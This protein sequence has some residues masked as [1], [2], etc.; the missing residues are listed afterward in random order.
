MV[1]APQ[2]L[3]TGAQG[4]LGSTLLKSFASHTTVLGLDRTAG[5]GIQAFDLTQDDYSPLHALKPELIVHCAALTDVDRCQT[6]FAQAY[7]INA[8]A[9]WKLAHTAR[10]LKAR[11]VYISTDFVFD[12]V[13]GNYTEEAS[14]NPINHYAMTKYLGELFVEKILPDALILR[15][16]ILYGKSGQAKFTNWAITQL[17]EGRPIKVVTDQIGTPTLVDDIAVALR[18]LLKQQATGLYH[19]AGADA[20]SRYAMAQHIA[21][22][23]HFDPSLVLPVTSREFPQVAPRPLNTS[24]NTRK[25]QEA[26][27]TMSTFAEG[28]R[29]MEA[30]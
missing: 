26:G 3:I 25:I 20:L 2:T 24:L 7:A 27:I 8:A 10:T 19:V 18:I 30:S 29:K 16:A 6:D 1:E 11:F 14:P 12:G 13:T 28:L 5:P 22:F 23:Y 15:V 9:T 4:L 17:R 21:Q